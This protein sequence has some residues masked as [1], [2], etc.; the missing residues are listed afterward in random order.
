[1]FTLKGEKLAFLGQSDFQQV[2]PARTGSLIPI[3][4]PLLQPSLPSN[5]ID[6]DQAEITSLHSPLTQIGVLWYLVLF[7]PPPPHKSS[8]PSIDGSELDLLYTHC[9]LKLG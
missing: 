1:V 3:V 9:Q 2:V 8:L 5:S 6:V 4:I 7:P